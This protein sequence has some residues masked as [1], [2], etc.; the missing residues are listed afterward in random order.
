V[1]PWI[2]AQPRLKVSKTPGNS[3]FYLMLNFRDK[4]L[5]DIRIRRAIAYSINR[6]TIVQ[7]MQRGAS[8]VATGMLAPENWAYYGDVTTYPFDPA[9]S[10]A[11]LDEAGYPKGSNGTRDLRFTYKTTPE[12]ARMAEAIQ[13]MLKRVGIEVDIRINEFA[14]FYGDIQNGN[15][16]LTAMKWVGINDPNHYYLVFDSKQVPPTGKNR[17]MYSNPEMDRL[18]EAGAVTLDPAE[19]KQIYAQVQKLAA[20][21]LPYVSL[22]W[23]DTVVAMNREL[24]GFTPYPNGSLISLSTVTL[25]SPVGSEPSF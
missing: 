21:D 19:R 14:T 4:R 23:D 3:Y 13:A 24:S 20:E 12:G 9:K 2:N 7:S 15:F 1:L 10:N 22:W 5:R 11:L 17:G 25:Q 8:R 18:V 6:N 16:D